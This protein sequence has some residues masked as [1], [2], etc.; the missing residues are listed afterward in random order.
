M[1]RIVYL[2]ELQSLEE[3]EGESSPADV[4]ACDVSTR[5]SSGAVWHVW[6]WAAASAPLQSLPRL[7]EVLKQGGWGDGNVSAPMGH[8]PVG[9]TCCQAPVG[10][11]HRYASP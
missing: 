3:E 9:E 1:K 5:I 10:S 7:E 6:V 2:F 11:F 4:E 8:I